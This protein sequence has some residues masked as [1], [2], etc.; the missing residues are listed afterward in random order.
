MIG[1]THRVRDFKFL[2]LSSTHTALDHVLRVKRDAPHW[3]RFNFH[4]GGSIRE[5]LLP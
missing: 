5:R 3:C 4:G 2:P 1:E